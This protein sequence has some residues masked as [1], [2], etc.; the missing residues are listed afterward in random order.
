M[1]R[2]LKCHGPVQVKIA[3]HGPEDHVVHHAASGDS[4]PCGVHDQVTHARF[5]LKV[6][7]HLNGLSSLFC[8]CTSKGERTSGPKAR[9]AGLLHNTCSTSTEGRVNALPTAHVAPWGSSY[10]WSREMPEALT[11]NAP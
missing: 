5:P 1:A 10:G 7:V 3:G 9:D 4:I 2:R 6:V 11:A 8:Q